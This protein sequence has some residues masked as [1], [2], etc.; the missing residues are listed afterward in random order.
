MSDFAHSL[1]ARGP[2]QSGYVPV[3]ADLYQIANDAG[4]VAVKYGAFFLIEQEPYCF[5]LRCVG[6]S[7]TRAFQAWQDDGERRAVLALF[8]MGASDE[9]V[10]PMLEARR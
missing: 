7:F 9:A 1:F 5:A 6:V 3:G 4:L 8:S 2:V 10:R